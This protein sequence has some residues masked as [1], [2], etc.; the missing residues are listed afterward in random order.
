MPPTKSK[1]KLSAHDKSTLSRETILAWYRAKRLE[2]LRVLRDEIVSLSESK[3]N[4]LKA[5]IIENTKKELAAHKAHLSSKQRLNQAE[6]FVEKLFDYALHNKDLSQLAHEIEKTSQKDKRKTLYDLWLK[7]NEREQHKIINES[8]R[9]LAMLHLKKSFLRKEVF[10]LIGMIEKY[11]D[12]DEALRV[13]KSCWNGNVFSLQPLRAFFSKERVGGKLGFYYGS[14][15]IKIHKGGFWAD[16][17]LSYKLLWSRWKSRTYSTFTV[18]GWW[19][20]DEDEKQKNNIKSNTV[21]P[22]KFLGKAKKKLQGGGYGDEYTGEIFLHKAIKHIRKEYNKQNDSG[23]TPDEEKEVLNTI[24][25]YKKELNNMGKRTVRK[26]ILIWFKK[27]PHD[28]WVNPSQEIVNLLSYAYGQGTGNY[29]FRYVPE[30]NKIYIMPIQGAEIKEKWFGGYLKIKNDKLGKTWHAFNK[31][32]TEKMMMAY[33]DTLDEETLRKEIIDIRLAQKG[34]E[35]LSKDEK[36]QRT[37]GMVDRLS[38]IPPAVEYVELEKGYLN[39][40]EKKIKTALIKRK[41]P[42]KQA[43]KLARIRSHYMRDTIHSLIDSNELIQE[44]IDENEKA[45]LEIRVDENDKIEV[46]LARGA[47][48]NKL[49]K[50]RKKLEEAETGIKA[51]EDKA[52]NRLEEKVEKFFG[53]LAPIAMWVLDSFFKIK[54]VIKKTFT[55]KRFS[56]GGM[57][58]GALG[59]GVS[60][61][62]IGSRKM[63]Q[64]RFDTLVSK[65]RRSKRLKKKLLFDEDTKLKKCTITIPR[66]KGIMLA[67]SMRLHVKGKGKFTAYPDKPK[68]GFSLGSLFGRLKR[69][70]YVYKDSP[71]VVESGTTIPKGTIIPKGAKIKSIK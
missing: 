7:N 43:E 16:N 46:K 2:K 66:G 6:K 70:K 67:E 19:T 68:K 48:R 42:E 9:Y 15:K 27:Q 32:E 65:I 21:F 41:I 5:K 13:Y 37:A 33:I 61:E 20:I 59:V 4:A 54:K 49:L 62:K 36:L 8:P 18:T 58:L 14:R 17:S 56:V 30:R 69:K 12:A 52:Y 44:A 60:R 35:H 71:I 22:R 45:K 64:E 10:L 3:R 47:L 51:M 55:G 11:W 39:I 26:N 50:A 40:I 23:L 57:I 63:T 29:R 24:D 28:V 1:E 53:P 38:G 31:K 34:A 25:T